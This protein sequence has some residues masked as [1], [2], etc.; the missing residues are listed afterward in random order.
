MLSNESPV[1]CPAARCFSLSISQVSTEY[2]LL[3]DHWE[4]A[5]PLA[6]LR[7]EGGR[8]LCLQ[9]PQSLGLDIS[10]FQLVF[11]SP[12]WDRNPTLRCWV[13]PISCSH[14]T[15]TIHR[16]WQPVLLLTVLKSA[17]A[18]W[19]T[20]QSDCWVERVNL[21]VRISVYEAETAQQIEYS[22]KQRSGWEGLHQVGD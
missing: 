15:F 16:P 8:L 5:T 17:S 3:E 9:T 13:G 22:F 12:K 19:E 6:N 18:I 14:L 20:E 21:G 1:M 2:K 7:V 11:C 10:A 4:S